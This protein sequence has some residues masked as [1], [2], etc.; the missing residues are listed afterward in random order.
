MVAQVTSWFLSQ[1]DNNAHSIARRFQL[2]VNST[3]D[4]TSGSA[5]MQVKGF[6]DHGL[7]SEYLGGD[8]DGKSARFYDTMQGFVEAA[9]GMRVDS[10]D[11]ISIQMRVRVDSEAAVD[12]STPAY[13]KIVPLYTFGDAADVCKSYV[14]SYGAISTRWTD[15]AGGGAWLTTSRYVVEPGDTN[16]L[17][18]VYNGSQAITYVGSVEVGQSNI[19]A[20]G[21]NTSHDL[22]VGTVWVS[23]QKWSYLTV[24]EMRFWKDALSQSDIGSY[25]YASVE[26]ID[27]STMVSLGLGAAWTFNDLQEYG[28]N[29]LSWP[30]IS[31]RWDEIKP[32]TISLEVAN[33]DGKFDFFDEDFT[34]LRRQTRLEIGLTHASSGPEYLP[35]HFGF[36]SAVRSR[37][38]NMELT[39]TDKFQELSEH[40]V[41]NRD[42]PVD[43]TSYLVSDLAWEICTNHGPLDDTQAPTN[44]DI[45]WSSFQAWAEVFSTSLIWMDAHCEGERCTDILG[46]I[47]HMTRSAI[48]IGRSGKV[49]FHRF[50]IADCSTMELNERHCIDNDITSEVDEGN[51]V[52][53]VYV[54]GGYVPDSGSFDFQVSRSTAHSVNTFGTREL[55]ESDDVV[56]LVDSASCLDLADRVLLVSAQPYHR[57][58][59]AAS[60]KAIVADVGD[61]ITVNNRKPRVGG[62]FRAMGTGVDMQAATIELDLSTDQ[63]VGGSDAGGGGTGGGGDPGGTGGDANEYDYFRLDYSEMDGTDVLA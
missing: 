47:A 58:S 18:F 55:E 49:Q 5:H 6:V 33:H 36:V 9:A 42:N 21:I 41:G 17:T 22:Y 63:I 10:G 4:V 62:A 40:I 28:S 1:V 19:G 2:A 30:K 15:G 25:H 60:F 35:M 11:P 7:V 53:T 56:W 45:D 31:Q 12:A 29:V 59:Y 26:N 23:G 38:A 14:D 44:I 39:I 16:L 48:Y 43:I 54:D 37:G 8:N 27:P 52:N 57:V 34:T 24:D 46:R 51:I 50:T 13:A 32:A 3:A 20:M 61:I